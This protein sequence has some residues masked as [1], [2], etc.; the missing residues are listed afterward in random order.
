[1]GVR[2]Q[3]VEVGLGLLEV[4]LARARS[5]SV[6]ATRGPT[7]SSASVTAVMSGSAGRRVASVTR[8]SRI[9]VLVSNTPRM[10]WIVG[11]VYKEP[12]Q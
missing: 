9:T 6:E 3:Q 2:R 11:S 7:E 8:G 10:G 12:V 1:M 5:A 4:R